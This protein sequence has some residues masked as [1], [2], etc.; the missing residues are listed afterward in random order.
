MTKVGNRYGINK[1]KEFKPFFFVDKNYIG[2]SLA[3]AYNMAMG[4]KHRPYRSGGTSRR[5]IESIFCDAFQGKLAEFGFYQYMTFCEIP[6][7]Y[8]DL[9][10]MSRGKWDTCDFSINDKSIC[11]KSTKRKGNLLLLE[12]KDWDTGGVYIHNRLKYDYVVLMRLDPDISVIK[13]NANNQLEKIIEEIKK[14]KWII[15]PTG[16]INNGEL[17][18]AMNNNIIHK[19][20]YLYTTRMDAENYYIQAGDLHPMRELPHLL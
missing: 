12:S 6:C 4:E 8:P 2:E 7:K 19:D 18:Y 17:Q 10:I 11:I 15:N 5:S 20:E 14:Q 13:R 16:F 1:F 3:F 9:Q